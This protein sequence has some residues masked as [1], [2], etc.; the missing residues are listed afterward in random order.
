MTQGMSKCESI[1]ILEKSA[2]ANEVS[3]KSLGGND[4]QTKQLRRKLPLSGDRDGKCAFVFEC[5]QNVI[6]RY[7]TLMTPFDS[8]CNKFLVMDGWD[9]LT[10]LH[11]YKV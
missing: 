5:C 2:L 8:P 10:D 4:T 7:S 11:L 3:L 9:H 1:R 6:S